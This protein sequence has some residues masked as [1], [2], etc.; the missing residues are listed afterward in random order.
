MNLYPTQIQDMYLVLD[1]LNRSDYKTSPE[2]IGI[3][4]SSSGGNLVEELAIKEGYPAT[5]WSGL[6]DLE[7]FYNKHKNTIPKKMI[8]SDNIAISE[9]Y[10]DGANDE[11]YKWLIINFLGGDMSKLHDATSI[12]RVNENSGTMLLINSIDELVP[13]EEILKLGEKLLKQNQ[14]F[15]ALILKGNRH[16]EGYYEDVIDMTIDFFKKY[17]L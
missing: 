16:G 7:G 4:G 6:F 2:K 14:E 17:L 10:Q 12:N 13:G 8:I 1:W 11:Y 5:A 3:F 15:Q 9:I